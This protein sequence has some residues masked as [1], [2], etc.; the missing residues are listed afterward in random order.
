MHITITFTLHLPDRLTRLS[1]RSRAAN[2]AAVGKTRKR[3]M[4]FHVLPQKQ[5]IT[6]ALG[7]E[8]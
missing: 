7:A 4:M 2:I 8:S 6:P 5:D 1:L 3:P